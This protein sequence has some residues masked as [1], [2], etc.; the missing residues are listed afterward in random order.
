[1][2]TIRRIVEQIK[3]EEDW[4]LLPWLLLPWCPWYI[5]Q[6]LQSRPLH[7]VRPWPQYCQCPHAD[8]HSHQTRSSTQYAKC[9]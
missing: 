9:I 7:D 5:F 6:A 2:Y 4:L 1:M 8:I 3:S